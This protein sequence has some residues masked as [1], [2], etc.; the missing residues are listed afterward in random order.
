MKKQ[1]IKTIKIPEL[2]SHSLN[3]N[4]L[5][6]EHNIDGNLEKQ[7]NSKLIINQQ[8]NLE[9]NLTKRSKNVNNQYNYQVCHTTE[10]IKQ[11]KNEQASIS[12]KNKSYQNNNNKSINSIVNKTDESAN[13]KEEEK[14]IVN[15]INYDITQQPDKIFPLTI[16][17]KRN[18]ECEIDDV[19]SCDALT[20]WKKT[21]RSSR[22]IST[23]KKVVDKYK[24]KQQQKNRQSIL[25]NLAL[26]EN[27]FMPKQEI[28]TQKRKCNIPVL[29]PESTIVIIW[30]IIVSLLMMYTAIIM[31][32]RIAFIETDSTFW[33]VLETIIDFLFL[34]DIVVIFNVGYNDE[35]E[36][37]IN[38]RGKI[39]WKYLT[40]WFFVDL[41]T[42]LPQNLMFS[43]KSENLQK[44]TDLLRLVKIAKLNRLIRVFRFFKLARFLRKFKIF[45]NIYEKVKIN[46]GMSKL[47]S[48][49]F[50]MILVFH[51]VACLWFFLSKLYDEH[52]NWYTNFGIR[53][54]PIIRKYFFSLY[55]TIT[56]IFTMGFGDIHSYN[57][58]E[59]AFSIIWMVFGVIFFSIIIGT[60]SSIIANSESRETILKKK[61]QILDDFAK[62]TSLSES[63]KRKIT[64]VLLFN[65]KNEQSI[66]N[67]D[68]LN[69][70]PSDLKYQVATAVQQG[71]LKDI[72]FLSQIMYPNFIAV[73]IQFLTPIIFIENEIVYEI[74]DTPRF[75]YFI[76][77]GRISFFTN[78]RIPYCT[79]HTGS[80]FGE[81]DINEQQR[82]HNVIS[83]ENS[84]FLSLSKKHFNEIFGK[85]F[86]EIYMQLIF[87][88]RK[89]KIRLEKLAKV[90]TEKFYNDSYDFEDNSSGIDDSFSDEDDV[91]SE[92][93]EK[94]IEQMIEENKHT[95]GTTLHRAS[96]LLAKK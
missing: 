23:M 84:D 31:P 46:F 96:S 44:G 15:P 19:N 22:G 35:N 11:E 49:I 40:G 89:R 8:D 24:A 5:L 26:I 74:G 63:L 66:N 69:D 47:I 81:I 28:T 17:T 33:K 13:L 29:N 72:V 20:L 51:V 88:A 37:L 57:A 41:I 21:L 52:N 12:L 32:F 80:H 65:S 59:N 25:M 82:I 79:F 64:F 60:L 94:K 9:Q 91:Y 50:Q 71:Y 45:D 58:L 92:N 42:S 76:L 90:V 54:D 6:L 53:D 85:D 39:A 36:D 3:S 48:F 10:N 2:T 83:T 18:S 30:N 4:S 68:L 75:M 67:Y 38:D 95:I 1:N 70:I 14:D 27:D 55:W 16:G 56:T 87:L 62:K 7:L 86:Q 93:E 61:L 77:K 73:I 78:E 43:A 34:L